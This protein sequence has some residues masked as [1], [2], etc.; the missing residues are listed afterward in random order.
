MRARGTAAVAFLL[1]AYTPALAD[2]VQQTWG[3]LD[4]AR[5][6]V[7]IGQSF[8]TAGKLRQELSSAQDQNAKFA[9]QIKVLQE[10]VARAAQKEAAPANSDELQKR[11]QDYE[12]SRAE[13]ERHPA[14]MLRGCLQIPG[15][16][17]VVR[18]DLTLAPIKIIR[19]TSNAACVSEK[20]EPIDEP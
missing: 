19:S 13:E 5:L 10:A 4:M 20:E 12:R 1:V 15:T 14:S 17:L 6:E 16:Q 8:Y 9:E 2:E 7:L 3:P 11:L 18:K